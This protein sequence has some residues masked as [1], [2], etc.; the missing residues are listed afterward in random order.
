MKRLDLGMIGSALFSLMVAF[1]IGGCGGDTVQ[2]KVIVEDPVEEIVFMYATVQYKNNEFMGT[3]RAEPA[4]DGNFQIYNLGTGALV[5]TMQADTSVSN[6]DGREL[7]LCDGATVSDTGVDG[8]CTLPSYK[9]EHCP[10][11]RNGDFNPAYSPAVCNS[12][13]YFWCSLARQCL[14]K[15]V[16]VPTC[17]EIGAR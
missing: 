14:N 10:D 1:M 12:N 17:G 9:V 7:G 3:T 2:E 13:G 8:N 16:N 6:I 5:G 11:T 4:I 15:P